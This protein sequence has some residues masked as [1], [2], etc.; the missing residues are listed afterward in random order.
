MVDLQVARLEVALG[1]GLGVV[2]HLAPILV[3]T[4][5]QGL[6]AIPRAP[7]R[8]QGDLLLWEEV[9]T[10]PGHLSSRAKGVLLR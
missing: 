8:H 7:H 5:E 3:E 1:L 6:G 9:E 2:V 10:L 4:L